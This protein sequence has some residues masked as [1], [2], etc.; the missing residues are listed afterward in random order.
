MPETFAAPTT[1]GVYVFRGPE[2]EVLYVGK[3]TNL[4]RRVL[5]HLHIREEKDALL[6]ESYARVEFVPTHSEREALLLEANLVR[7]HRPRYNVLLKDDKSYPY[8][9]VTTGD[10]F[11]RISL[12]RRPRRSRKAT[13]F[14][15]YTSAREARSLVWVLEDSFHTRRCIRL[16]KRECIYYHMGLCPAPCTGKISREDYGKQVAQALLV[17]QGRTGEA[18]DQLEREM[19][20]AA[21]HQEFERAILLRDAMAAVG[22]L[23]EKQRVS[24]SGSE[25]MD[26]LALHYPR[27]RPTLTATVGLLRVRAGQV[28]GAEPHALSVPAEG[29]PSDGDL[30]ASY[31]LQDYSRRSGLPRVLYIPALSEP[32]R[33]DLRGATDLLL[34][35]RGIEVWVAERGRPKALLEL[36]RKA[37][38]TYTHVRGESLPHAGAPQLLQRMLSL[39]GLPQHIEG[40][41][42]SIL[43]GVEAV[44]SLVVFRG[45]K[46]EK[47]E[48]RRFKIKEVEGMNDF[49]MIHEVVSRR[50]RRLLSERK[51]LP[52]LLLIDGGAGQVSS[53]YDALRSLGLEGRVPMLGLAKKEEEIYRPNSSEPLRPDKNSPAML[54]LRHI[55]DES[56]RF[57]VTYHRKRRQMA[58]RSELE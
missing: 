58:M 11:P 12:V 1:P 3:S 23:R 52:D 4:K 39:P 14:G 38:E 50:F 21:E 45:G 47:D 19:A 26:I 9:Q 54:L 22:N 42:I 34:T 55:R 15:P 37:A 35:D 30:L 46:P 31:L 36:A 20:T 48:Y 10:P 6:V 25:D 51:E 5:D 24:S 18:L 43:Q 44:G 33:E 2:G 7:E 56:H 53:A 32:D 49:A 17:L 40:I 27:E 29:D 28:V 13:L 16:P 41:D 57:A 8:I